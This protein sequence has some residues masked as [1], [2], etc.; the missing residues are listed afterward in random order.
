[1]LTRKSSIGKA[2]A[3][4]MTPAIGLPMIPITLV[5][6]SN[7]EESAFSTMNAERTFRIP[8]NAAV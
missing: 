2:T 1:M 8:N 5:H 3:Q 7:I 4:S 6:I